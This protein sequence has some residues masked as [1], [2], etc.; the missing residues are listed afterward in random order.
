M[1][2]N[3][4]CRRSRLALGSVTVKGHSMAMEI[5]PNMRRKYACHLRDQKSPN[6]IAL[7]GASMTGGHTEGDDP[8][9]TNM[10]ELTAYGTARYTTVLAQTDRAVMIWRSGE[11]YPVTG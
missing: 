2:K 6:D 8:S 3:D 5:L 11:R 7:K 9:M 1:I 10:L 4:I